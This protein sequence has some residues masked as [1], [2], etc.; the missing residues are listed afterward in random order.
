MMKPPEDIACDG[1]KNFKAL[2]IRRDVCFLQEILHRSLKSLIFY[3]NLL[4][5]SKFLY[6]FS[7]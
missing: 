3:F 4:F 5:V 7:F 2:E 1:Y 6:K